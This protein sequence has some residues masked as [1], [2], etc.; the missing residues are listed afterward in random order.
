MTRLAVALLFLIAGAAGAVAQETRIAAVVNDEVI[1]LG[2][3]EARTQLILL[4]SQL[5]DSAQ[6]RQRVMPQVLRSLI[7]ERLQIQEA[8]KFNIVASD[9]DVSEAFNRLEQQ[10]GMAK[11]NL[12]KLLASRGIPRSTLVTQISAGIV[13]NKLVEG[14]YGASASVSDDEINETM[15][16]IKQDIGRP[17]HHV[18]EIF[19]SVDKP[20]QEADVKALADRLAEQIRQGASFTAVAQQF[21]QSPTA[22]VGGDLGWLS[23]TELPRDIAAAVEGM[24]PGQLSAPIRGAAGFY[25]LFLAERRVFGAPT[26]EDTLVTLSRVGFPFPPNGTDADKQRVLAMAQQVSETVKS[27]GELTKI[28]Q[29]RAPQTSGEVRD[30]KLGSLPPTLQTIIAPLQIAEASKPIP[31]QGGVGVVMVCERKAP[32]SQIP[33]KDQLGNNMARARLETLGR[34]YLRDLRRIAFVDMRV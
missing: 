27:C 23:P 16:R 20:D 18:A 4:S 31:A 24:Q 28:G 25:L 21:S 11:G 2:D 7:D 9:T 6:V 10:N 3:L 33:T 29:E 30:A 8:K 5:P 13:W 22:A 17:Q 12:D 19:L 34:R 32:P 15:A 14:K 1:S 26:A